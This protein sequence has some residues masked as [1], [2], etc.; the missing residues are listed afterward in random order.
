MTKPAWNPAGT[1]VPGAEADTPAATL[2]LVAA[3]EPDLATASQ[4]PGDGMRELYDRC[5]ADMVRFAAFLTGRVDAAED[6][7]QDAFVKVFAAWDRIDDPTR[8]DAYVKTTVVNLVRGGHRREQVAERNADRP[9]SV[10][11]S[12]EKT[13]S[14]SSDGNAC[15][16]RSQRCRCDN[17]RAWSCGTGCG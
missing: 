11:P 14:A 12:A 10:V 4:D 8:A 2:R 13:R 1:E 9:L 17:E 6:I 5:H 16:T 3:V 7:A 15:S